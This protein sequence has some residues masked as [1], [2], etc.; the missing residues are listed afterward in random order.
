MKVGLLYVDDF[1][2]PRSQRIGSLGLAYISSFLKQELEGIEV[3]IFLTPQAI[4][5]FS[6]D[7]VGISAYSETLPMAEAYAR[8]IKAK[9]DIPVVLGGP[10]ITSAP[11]D[12]P[13]IFDVGVVGEGEEAFT[14]LALLMKEN[15]FTPERLGAIQG[16]SFYR[17]GELKQTG[18]CP[19]IAS[20]DLLA[21]PDR[22]HMFKPMYDYWSDFHPMLHIHTARGC[23]YRCTFCSA[24]L[25]NPTW[26]HHSPE[27]VVEELEII[28]RQFP[29]SKELTISDDLFT[30]DIKRLEPL[31]KAIRLAGLHKRFFFFCSA[32]SN[33]LS[34]EICQLLL[35]MNVLVISFGLESASDRLI[36]E[37]KGY[38]TDKADY[39]RILE[40]CSEYGLHPH[41]NF[42]LGHQSERPQ[43]LLETYQFIRGN[44]ERF[45]SLYFTHM[46]PLPGTKVWDDAIESNLID[47]ETINYKHLDLTF[48]P[49]TSL[50]INQHYSSEFYQ[51]AYLW[52]KQ[53]ETNLND[54]YYEEN[55]LIKDIAYQQRF[56]IPMQ[57]LLLVKSLKVKKVLFVSDTVSLL[58][59]ELSFEMEIV[60]P[61]QLS[62]NIEADLI[63]LNYTLEQFQDP[64]Q[65]LD[66]LPK[67]PIVSL[68]YHVG[69]IYELSLLLLGRWDEGFYS[70]RQRK[71]KRFYTLKTLNALFNSRSMHSKLV[72]KHH[73]SIALPYQ[74]LSFLNH[75]ATPVDLDV[76]SYLSL[77]SYDDN[78]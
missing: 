11:E 69:N 58:P 32:R 41:G 6:P 29:K 35:D 72:T 50:F 63:V 9:L 27:W 47:L 77:W 66:R 56:V 22:Q 7:L 59:G 51:H 21:H 73:Y 64:S 70:V 25:V 53:F 10:H 39:Q 14:K 33:T 37:L 19:P 46:T 2:Q 67:V 8:E 43:E 44:Q 4:L 24:P 3:E 65:L 62:E 30:L 26:R 5:K 31:V 78:H 15:A 71:N 1:A 17:N 28:A 20:M 13:S 45:A 76:F 74:Q 49:E 36:R 54:R 40:L 52:F 60:N 61:T 38:G 55:S 57:V 42:I 12:M 48:N 16:V 68:N 23:P 75:I 34:R 18:R